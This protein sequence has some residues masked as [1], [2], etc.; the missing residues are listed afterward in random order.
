MKHKLFTL[1]LMLLLFMVSISPAHAQSPSGDQLILG[2]NHTIGANET[3]NGD[4]YVAG[5]N[6]DM[7]ETATINGDLYVFGGNAN[8]DG[9]I[10][11][12][13]TVFGGNADLTDTAVVSGNINVFGGN[14]SRD[15]K[16]S[17]GG[18]VEQD[19]HFSFD[20]DDDEGD[21]PPHFGPPSSY[22]GSSFFGRV[23]GFF[24]DTTWN[25]ML[26]IGLALIGWVVAAFLPEQM[27]V[28][29]ETV[30][31]TKLLSF[32]MGLLTA[33]LALVLIIPAAL[34]FVTICLAIVPIAGYTLLVGAMLLGWIVM[35]QLIGERLLTS[36]E[37]PL[38]SLV[39]S[40]MVGVVVLTIISNMPIIGL[41]PIIGTIF[42]FIGWLFGVAVVLTGLGAV[43]LTRFGTRPYAP[44]GS[45]FGTGPAAYPPYSPPSPPAART[46]FSRESQAEAE[47][48]ARIK[49]AL[50]EADQTPE[51][52]PEPV[53][54]EADEPAEPA[55]TPSK[56]KR[57]PAAKKT[58][59]K[60]SDEPNNDGSDEA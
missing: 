42:G 52:E 57:K 39:L 1:S 29:G 53:A 7:A 48:K 33:I 5:G 16:A 27:Q 47:L 41:I 4:V 26:L 19:K 30:S 24:I 55:D 31:Q 36:V 35:G 37:R 8:I 18:Q 21:G 59:A 51:P 9:T 6:L 45:S 14:L 50:A 54:P 13:I 34:M 40:T 44:A 60:D 15:E 17:I 23:A 49:A 3:I 46:D 43:V 56:P 25:V 2:N 38:P 58:P 11:G 20:E 28:V 32:G 12:D 10:T 22:D